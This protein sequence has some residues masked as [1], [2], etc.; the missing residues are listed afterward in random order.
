M[1]HK[2]IIAFTIISILS[3]MIVFETDAVATLSNDSEN[4]CSGS[5]LDKVVYDVFPGGVTAGPLALQSGDIDVLYDTMDWVNEDT[6]NSDPDIGLFYKY[7]N[8]YGHLT[9]NFRDYPLNISGLRRAFAY[10]YDKTKVCS[11]V[12]DGETIVHDSIVPLP[13]IWCIE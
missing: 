11:D 12:R 6:L 13:N 1:I 4:P 7:S 5:Y 8:G 2:A 10:A 3:V 9:I